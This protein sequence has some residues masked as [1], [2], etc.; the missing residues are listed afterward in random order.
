M[1]V[2]EEYQLPMQ[3]TLATTSGMVVLVDKNDKQVGVEE[4][5]TAHRKGL[6]HRAFSIF[7]F[8]S[9]GRLLIQK[10][11]ASKYHSSNLWSN[12]CC[13]HP[14][15][16]ESTEIAA[17]RRLQEEMGINVELQLVF[18]FTYFAELGNGLFESELDHVFRGSF[19]DCPTPDLSEVSDW[20][21]VDM[22]YL[23]QDIQDQP[24]RY[25]YWLKIIINKGIL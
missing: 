1:S 25:T 9:K 22:E 21:W 17:R 11:S 4:K 13:S 8:D 23:R 14:R 2:G 5:I 7:I 15:P 3:K 24:D 12:T 6:L 16:G 20:K 19:D 18:H 10:R